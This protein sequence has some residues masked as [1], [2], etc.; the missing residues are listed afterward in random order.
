[1]RRPADLGHIGRR[2]SRRK[3][4]IGAVVAVLFLLVSLVQGAAVFYTDFLWFGSVDLTSVFS[5]MLFTKIGLGVA[6]FLLFFVAVYANLWIVD[7]FA[8]RSLSFDPDEELSRRW[9]Q[10]VRPRAGKVRLIIATLFGLFAGPGFFINWS[11][12]MLFRNGGNF[13]VKD[14]IFGMD[15]G[16]F[17]FKLPFLS[18][19]VTWMFYA[20]VL[21]LFVAVFGH[22]LQGAIRPQAATNRVT[23][24]V[25]THVS[26]LIGLIALLRA[27]Q[28]MID[29]YELVFSTRGVAA[30]ANYT[31]VKFL[32]PAYLLLVGISVLAA[33]VVFASARRKGWSLTGTTIAIW[34]ITSLLV[35]Q[36]IPFGVQ[37][38]SVEPAES[39][40]EAPY[41]DRNI[42][43]TR[44]AFGLDEIQV[45]DF[46]YTDDLNSQN[47]ENN[48]QTIRNVRL[49]DPDLLTLPY[50]R[51]QENRSF[52]KFEGIDIDRYRLGNSDEMTQLALSVRELNVNG[53]PDDRR[54]WVN[55]HLQYTHGYG[56]VAS[57]ANAVTSDGS[58]QFSLKDVPPNGEPSLQRP[59]V[60]FGEFSNEYSIVKSKQVEVDYVAVDGRDATS[61]Y[62][63]GGGVPLSNLFKRAAFA[64]RVGDLNPLIS[65]LV[66]NESRAMYF[67]NI[68]E[69]TREVAPF[70]RYDNDPYPVIIDGHIKWIQDAYTTTNHYP[71]GQAA[72][73]ALVEQGSG[74]SGGGYNYVRNSVK[75][76]TDAYDGDMTFYVN[77]GNDPIIKAWQKT[78]PD[79][80]TPGDQMPQELREHLRYPEDLFRVQATMFGRYHLTNTGDFYSQ[81]DRWNLAQ[82][83]QFGA[84]AANATTTA[85][86]Q[87][88]GGLLPQSTAPVGEQR[89]EPYYLLMRLPGEQDTSFLLFQPFVPFSSGD[90]RKEL[91]AFLTAKSDPNNYGQLDAF[92]MPRDRQVDGPALVEARIQQDPTIAQQITL[93]NQ[94]GSRV[95]LGNM[96]IIPIDNG[97]LYVRPLYVTSRQT[98]VPEFKKAIVVQGQDIAMEDTLQEALSKV[99]GAAP[100]T[101]E[102]NRD[103]GASG[104]AAQPGVPTPGAAAP[105]VQDL[106]NQ[107][108]GAFDN[109]DA[110]LRAGDLSRF[111]SEINRGRDLIR[112]AQAG[113]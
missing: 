69:R 17:V 91:S 107:A 88:Q 34:A 86:P 26:I 5:T 25:K 47:L 12:W 112:K 45:K 15:V 32:L 103:P 49:W 53:L 104:P 3:I 35:V 76:V 73:T 54:S 55:R 57:P 81:S 11:D 93:L 24:I 21:S 28:Y 70:L 19:L 84:A 27:A 37:K 58:P 89:I 62:E 7:R 78:F 30:G 40:K 74:L 80:F 77:D 36:A 22:F 10:F 71:Y 42:N 29:R 87:P 94:G 18:T 98:Q 51:L 106:L 13:G 60:Y 16:F 14:P 83:P 2:P 68:K 113:Q 97:L 8:P 6:G 65:D 102:E 23:S 50:Q 67:N 101:L 52:F 41:L 43:A 66:T 108:N 100:Q 75:V 31:D 105:G 56:T 90:Q 64:A 110:A 92:V 79:L 85:A 46:Q 72:D 63:G 82:K 1:M 38:L 61:T 111:Q 48:A 96:L 4:G 59:Q 44:A 99:F 9:Q 39:Q 20:L 109:A 33:I 95:E